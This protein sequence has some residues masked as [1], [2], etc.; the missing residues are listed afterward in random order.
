[1]N[2]KRISW[3]T[4]LHDESETNSTDNDVALE[5]TSPC[6]VTIASNRDLNVTV[7]FTNV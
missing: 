3:P 6:N 7:T 4:V 2:V 5:Q 1:M